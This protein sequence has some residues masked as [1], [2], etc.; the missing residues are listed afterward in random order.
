M[1]GKCRLD[2]F[3]CDT[4]VVALG[5]PTT[6][7]LGPHQDGKP[8]VVCP[9]TPIFSRFMLMV[10]TMAFRTTAA[11]LPQQLGGA[12]TILKKWCRR[13]SPKLFSS[14]I[15]KRWESRT[16]SLMRQVLACW[17]VL[18]FLD[19][20]VTDQTTARL[21]LLSWKIHWEGPRESRSL[22]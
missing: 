14:T 16:V 4:R 11:Q 3:Q 6:S 8:G 9:H 20:L 19:C 18:C 17:F 1:G 21:P 22:F 10:P 13:S 12:L 5:N 7:S 2:P 15:S